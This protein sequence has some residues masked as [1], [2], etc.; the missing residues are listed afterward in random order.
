M[1]FCVLG[2][3]PFKPCREIHACGGVGAFRERSVLLVVAKCLSYRAE[4][5]FF[6]SFKEALPVLRGCRGGGVAGGKARKGPKKGHKMDL[7]AL[8]VKAESQVYQTRTERFHNTAYA[9]IHKMGLEA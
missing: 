2:W 9:N 7:E 3:Y 8:K 4:L 6:L 5:L 1:F